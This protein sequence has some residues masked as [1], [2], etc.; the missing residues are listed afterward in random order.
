[1]KL[2]RIQWRGPTRDGSRKIYESA[3]V[4]GVS[5]VRPFYIITHHDHGTEKWWALE[6][7][8]R[9]ILPLDADLFEWTLASAKRYAQD[10]FAKGK[11]T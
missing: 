9:Q 1:M 3:N 11:I 4:A 10:H 5:T 8:D 2:P 7:D 6:I